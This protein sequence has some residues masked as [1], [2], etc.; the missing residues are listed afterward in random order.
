MAP[1]TI[2][3]MDAAKRP[4]EL[5]VLLKQLPRIRKLSLRWYLNQGEY[6]D[7]Y[8][9]VTQM[10]QYP[11]PFLESY[12]ISISQKRDKSPIKVNNLFNGQCPRLTNLSLHLYPSEFDFDGP[13]PQFYSNLRSFT[14]SDSR[15]ANQAMKKLSNM[16]NLEYLDI[17]LSSIAD[18]FP[19]STTVNLPRLFGL[20]LRVEFPHLMTSLNHFVFPETAW[21]EITS[22]ISED[23]EEKH[24]SLMEEFSQWLG[25]RFTGPV[26]ALELRWGSLK[27][28]GMSPDHP[29]LQ[30]DFTRIWKHFLQLLLHSL[31]L[32]DMRSLKALHDRNTYHNTDH[33][34]K[35][36]WLAHFGALNHLEKITTSWPPDF[37]NAFLEGTP[38]AKKGQGADMAFKALRHL[39]LENWNLKK[40][41]LPDEP[42]L[43]DVKDCLRARRK[44]N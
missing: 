41:F 10:L 30:L 29:Q 40:P 38:D 1:L 13:T 8:Q 44:L 28:W 3:V 39:T 31:P 19:P 27:A 33:P 42:R 26:R 20:R 9:E 6:Q 37:L 35:A 21:L 32:Q 22:A 16:P 43:K 25:K 14:C 2:E 24:S 11:A 7:V 36:S 12:S 23:G 15:T 5:R 34:C 18:G 4:T 17:N